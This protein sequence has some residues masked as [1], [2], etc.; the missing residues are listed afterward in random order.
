[1]HA[2]LAEVETIL[3]AE[4]W[5]APASAREPATGTD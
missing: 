5:P 2:H 3:M 1:M 4:D